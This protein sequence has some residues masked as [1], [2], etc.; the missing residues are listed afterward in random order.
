MALIKYKPRTPGTRAVKDTEEPA[1]R[2]SCPPRPGFISTL[3]MSEPTGMWRSDMALP[4]LIG[5]S[6]PERTSSPAFIPLAARM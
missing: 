3:W 2:A 1:L 6:A 4:D 5:A